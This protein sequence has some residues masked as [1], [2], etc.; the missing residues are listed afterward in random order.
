MAPAE[1]PDQEPQ[2]R[3][4]PPPDSRPWYDNWTR[5][6]VYPFREPGAKSPEPPA[7]DQIPRYIANSSEPAAAPPPEKDG[8]AVPV[9]KNTGLPV[10]GEWTR[11]RDGSWLFR[12]IGDPNISTRKE[13]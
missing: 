10:S 9:D 1:R 8:F 4:M 7:Q 12:T 2:Y 13:R 3:Y 5:Q 6:Y 11:D